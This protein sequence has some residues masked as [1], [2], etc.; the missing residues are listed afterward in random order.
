MPD[1]DWWSAATCMSTGLK[2]L[3]FEAGELEKSNT[4]MGMVTPS[5]VKEEAGTCREHLTF[6]IL[7]HVDLTLP[8]SPLEHVVQ[9][10]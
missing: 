9:F 10:T 8:T 6:W 1:S 2:F 3:A 5:L 7:N 4:K